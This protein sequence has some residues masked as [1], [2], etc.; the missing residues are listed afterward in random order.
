MTVSFMRTVDDQGFCQLYQAEKKAR[1]RWKKVASDCIFEDY[2]RVEFNSRKDEKLT[3]T[4][5]VCNVAMAYMDLTKAIDKVLHVT[6]CEAGPIPPPGQAR[7]PCTEDSL[8][9]DGGPTRKARLAQRGLR[10]RLRANGDEVTCAAENVKTRKSGHGVRWTNH[11]HTL[12]TDHQ[13]HAWQL[14][15]EI[16]LYECAGIVVVSGDGL[17]HE[18]INGLMSR[19]DWKAAMKLPLGIIPAGSGNALAAA[20]NHNAGFRM[21]TGV[22]LLVNCVLLLCRGSGRGLATLL[23]LVSVTTATGRRL[24]SFLSVAWGLVADV[25]VEGER[26]RRSGPA[27]FTLGTLGRLATLRR[28]PGRL[29]YLPAVPRLRRS[30]T[31]SPGPPPSRPPLGRTL[32]DSGPWGRGHDH[33]PP[34]LSAY[35]GFSF[36][37]ASFA[38]EEEED[39]EVGAEGGEA[40]AV[41]L[42]SERENHTRKDPAV[43]SSNGGS[44]PE[45]LS[46]ENSNISASKDPCLGCGGPS[47]R[48]CHDLGNANICAQNDPGPVNSEEFPAQ[49]QPRLMVER[50]SAREDHVQGSTYNLARKAPGSHSPEVNNR[51]SQDPGLITSEMGIPA[52]GSVGRLSDGDI[53]GPQGPGVVV[54]IQRPP[55]A[56]PLP[57]DDLLPPPGAPLPQDW[58]TVEGDFVLVLAIYQSHLGAELMTVPPA[59]FAQGAIHLCYVMAGIS[60]ASLL[61]LFLAMEKGAHFDLRCPHL[62]Y[63]PAT[64]F[65]IEP[66]G[67]RP[68]GIVTVDG[69]RVEYGTVQG[70]I[71]PGLARLVTGFP[72]SPQASGH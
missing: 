68:A 22:E 58:V 44:T 72:P 45:G 36:E 14:V 32:S 67:G 34:P 6:N 7:T 63:V 8:N 48:V 24:F 42:N 4:A 30:G 38:E 23:D 1:V 65:R 37:G 59:Q 20:V 70:Q 43:V 56:H 16:K 41:L 9:E 25:D 2:K 33:S 57:R 62:T 47:V 13:N 51:V 39:D 53:S 55:S 18:V 64:A 17:L 10:T 69:E 50:D 46:S 21:S 5:G 29:S 11:S 15:Q 54:R 35:E 66:L 27:R 49:E 12:S 3:E 52:S 60:R 31:L 28:Y 40:R 26:L 61:R 19:A 71:H